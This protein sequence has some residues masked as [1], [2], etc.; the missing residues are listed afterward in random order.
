MVSKVSIVTGAN[1]GIGLAVC[2]GLRKQVGGTVIL[3]ARNEER[4]RAAVDQLRAEGCET[5]FEQL[6]IS[7]VDSI[8]SFTDRVYNKYKGVDI[9]CNNAGH[10]FGVK[11]TNSA[12]EKAS[13][14]MATNLVGTRNIT[15]TILPIMK[16]NSRICNVAALLGI[17]NWCF[18]DPFNPYRL[19]LLSD[20]LT[21]GQV[22]EIMDDYIK[23]MEHED[24][25]YFKDSPYAA[26]LMSKVLLIAMTR[27]QG[28]SLM[29]DSRGIMINSCFPGFVNTDLS[30]NLGPLTPDKGAISPLMVCQLPDGAGNGRFF[31]RKK[32]VD[33]ATFVS[34]P[35]PKL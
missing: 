4:G 15:N 29:R 32:R 24:F 21:E 20:S 5:V 8:T 26:Y 28:V 3:T 10:K 13:V 30:G 14:T 9:L 25:T 7:D 33:W 18:P 6:D 19:Q 34:A 27:V 2:R 1:K 35:A 17:L 31:N 12:Y 23:A 16:E 22:L 11:T